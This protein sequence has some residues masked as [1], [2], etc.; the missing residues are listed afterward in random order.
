MESI[1]RNVENLFRHGGIIFVENKYTT[2]AVG[3]LYVQIDFNK[4]YRSKLGSHV[5]TWK[6]IWVYR[7]IK[8]F[9]WTFMM[10]KWWTVMSFMHKFYLNAGYMNKTWLPINK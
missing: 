5:M 2:N 9:W 10:V 3:S 8:S 1:G 7:Q 4:P 6:N